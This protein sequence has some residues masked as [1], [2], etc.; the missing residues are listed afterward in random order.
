MG[1]KMHGLVQNYLKLNTEWAEV[2]TYSKY[3][4]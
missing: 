2:Y 1:K 4:A 3:L